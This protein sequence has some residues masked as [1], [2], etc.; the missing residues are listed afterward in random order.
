MKLSGLHSY[1][2]RLNSHIFLL[3]SL[4]L[5]FEVWLWK[6]LAHPRKTNRK[7]QRA[8]LF[9]ITQGCLR[10]YY[11]CWSQS[12]AKMVCLPAKKTQHIPFLCTHTHTC[13]SAQ[14]QDRGAKFLCTFPILKIKLNNSSTSLCNVPQPQVLSCI[15]KCLWNRDGSQQV[16]DRTWMH[17]HPRTSS[18]PT[19][20]CESRA[21]PGS[22]W[23]PQG[24]RLA[25]KPSWSKLPGGGMKRCRGGK[26]WGMSSI[27]EK[28]CSEHQVK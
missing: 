1:S 10:R 6:S 14:G 27:G 9:G 3:T 13:T 8:V 19:W 4:V 18:S 28:I 5:T 25:E 24:H 22:W 11:V 15:W 26:I 17:R 12:T 16:Q 21:A 23:G 2:Q 20:I 7:T